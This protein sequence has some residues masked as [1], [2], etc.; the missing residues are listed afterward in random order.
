MTGTDYLV[1]LETSVLFTDWGNV[2]LTLR[3]LTGITEHLML[4]V[5]CHIN[6]CH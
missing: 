2:W 3:N 1:L 6:Q 5:R 4:Y